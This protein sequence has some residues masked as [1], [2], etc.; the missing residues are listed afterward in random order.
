MAVIDMLDHGKN[1]HAISAATGLQ[2]KTVRLIAERLNEDRLTA[3]TEPKYEYCGPYL[4]AL[5]PP[6]W[7]GRYR[8]TTPPYSVVVTQ[9]DD[10]KE[11]GFFSFE[12]EREAVSYLWD[13]RLSVGQAAEVFDAAGDEWIARKQVTDS[14]LRCP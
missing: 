13:M 14:H 4:L 7:W 3:I 11:I 12:E 2:Y 6:S 10:R 8:P 1:R 5:P 9:L